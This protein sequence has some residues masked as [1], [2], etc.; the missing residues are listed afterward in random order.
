MEVGWGRATWDLCRGD[1]CAVTGGGAVD[2]ECAGGD[3]GA[4]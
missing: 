1:A 3:D 2:G 4:S